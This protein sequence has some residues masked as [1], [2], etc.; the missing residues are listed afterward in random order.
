ME[1]LMQ[2]LDSQGQGGGA[3]YH[4]GSYRAGAWT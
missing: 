1:M 4:Q 2:A 3:K